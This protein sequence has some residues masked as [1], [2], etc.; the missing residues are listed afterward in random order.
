L[1]R[2]SPRQVNVTVATAL[3]EWLPGK[4]WSEVRN[5]LRA[6]RVTVSGNLCLDEGRRLKAD[7]VVKILAHPAAPPPQEQDVRIRYLDAHVVVVEKPAGMTTLR[8]PE[9][10]RWPAARR[11]RQP[12]LDELLPRII[13][14]R[15][16]GSGRHRRRGGPQNRGK[17]RDSAA[18]ARQ[19]VRRLRP[20]HRIDRETSG[21]MVFAR[22][23]DAER[24]LGLQF[25]AHSLHRRYLAIA[26]GDV[27][28]ETIESRLVDDRGDGR[29]GST[30]NPKLGKLAVTHVRPIERLGEHT[31]VECRLETGRTH[32]IRIHLSERGHPLCGDKV[33]RGP[34]PDR[35]IPDNS[36]APRLAL[37]AAELGF[38]HPVTREKL[39]F[40]MPLPAD[41]AKFAERLKRPA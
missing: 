27:R 30:R 40:S 19:V 38:E 4:S 7:E 12:T 23:V 39:L 18:P 8:H 20:V 15:E 29:R 41:L 1:L 5:L 6:R 9:E 31:L 16:Q 34:Y 21:L 13:A 37:H 32:Q 3:R 33:Y 10:R 22:T 25:R 14:R 2:V 26:W 28:E 17:R 35:P 36:G 24:L 11:Q